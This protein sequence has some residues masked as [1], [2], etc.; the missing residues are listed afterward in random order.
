MNPLYNTEDYAAIIAR[1]AN[2]FAAI[3]A[4]LEI[5]G[6]HCNF[7]SQMLYEFCVTTDLERRA[8]A[9][10]QG[11]LDQFVSTAQDFLETIASQSPYDKARNDP[12]R[13]PT[14][15]SVP[16]S[17][18]LPPAD[19]FL[20]SSLSQ[21]NLQPVSRDSRTYRGDRRSHFETPQPQTR[22]SA[23]S[24]LPS[25]SPSSSIFSIN[26]H[27][28]TP[29]ISESPFL[30]SPFDFLPSA[31]TIRSPSPTPVFT[32][33]PPTSLASTHQ[34]TL[35]QADAKQDISTSF[36]SSS[37]ADTQSKV[38]TKRARSSAIPRKRSKAPNICSECGVES[39]PHWRFTEDGE[40]LCNACGLAYLGRKKK[41]KEAA[42]TSS[43]ANRG[44]I[45]S[46]L[47]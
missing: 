15:V 19:P 16:S 37:K 17:R 27:I 21:P 33:H 24:A 38:P 13:V 39:T 4:R 25:P 8:V 10:L 1:N 45:A 29:T 34:T 18:S 28:S 26:S 3:R 32:T 22:V 7:A 23:P 43:K 12:F 31:E 35:T 42:S 9:S 2:T 11:A 46:I 20:P 5:I 14:A 44:S 36:A 41:A 47:N 30:I 6:Q 40:R